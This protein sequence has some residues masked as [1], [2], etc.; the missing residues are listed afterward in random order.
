MAGLIVIIFSE[1]ANM[2]TSCVM[3]ILHGTGLRS[4]YVG[5]TS[6]L[7]NRLVD[8][9]AGKNPLASP[10]MPWEV[11]WASDPMSK[12]DAMELERRIKV[13]ESGGSCLI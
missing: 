13:P 10:G 4:R 12:G 9:N 3:Y 11:V 7:P 2:Q 5:H 8:H 1:R 6:D